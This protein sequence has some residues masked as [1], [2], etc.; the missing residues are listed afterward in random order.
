MAIIVFFLLEIGYLV[1]GPVQ[2]VR[3]KYAPYAPPLGTYPYDVRMS[4]IMGPAGIVDVEI[5]VAA[6]PGRR[7][8]DVASV[9]LRI[10]PSYVLMINHIAANIAISAKILLEKQTSGYR[11]AGYGWFRHSQQLS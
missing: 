8:Y 2:L 9:L 7:L 4:C 1:E 3:V 6:A 10:L 5:A 11:S